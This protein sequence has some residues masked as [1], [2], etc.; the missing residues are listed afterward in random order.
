M[1]IK[2]LIGIG[3]TDKKLLNTRHNVGIWY[4]KKIM[5]SEKTIQFGKIYKIFI[6]KKLIF[7]Y[8]PNSYINCSGKYVYFIK[9]KLNLKNKEIL[10]IHDEI[11]LKPGKAKFTKGGKCTHNGIKD[12]IKNLKNK[13]NFYRLK[14]GIGNTSI[15]TKLNKYVL[16]IPTINEKKLI[17][18]SIKKAI[19]CTKIWISDNNF[20]KAQ[21]I[22]NS[23][24]FYS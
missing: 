10:I 6:N 2:I 8:I 11:N 16:S 5:T 1:S 4:I 15:K 7:I 20:I 24:N 9:K 14:I 19:E 17:I 21:N 13:N 3:N 18:K 22:L 23:L 12:I